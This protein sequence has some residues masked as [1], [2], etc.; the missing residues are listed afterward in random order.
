MPD[1]V[2][3]VEAK[4]KV[5]IHVT[6][7]LVRV[8]IAYRASLDLDVV[9]RTGAR[10]F[11]PAEGRMPPRKRARALRGGRAEA[12]RVKAEPAEPA[13]VAGPDEIRARFPPTIVFEDPFANGAGVYV[14]PPSDW[15]DSGT[16]RPRASRGKCGCWERPPSPCVSRAPARERTKGKPAKRRRAPRRAA[17]VSRKKK[18]SAKAKTPLRSVVFSHLWR[19]PCARRTAGCGATTGTA[20]ARRPGT[21]RASPGT[22]AVW[23]P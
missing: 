22:T 14:K 21:P 10:R 17:G 12:R 16:E 5:A 4:R 7:F 13:A 18:V 8:V 23:F 11:L 2:R 1:A 20:K 19:T 9:R 15:N 3:G 6:Y